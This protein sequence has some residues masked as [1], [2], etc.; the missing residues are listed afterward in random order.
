MDIMSMLDVTKAIDRDVNAALNCLPWVTREV[1]PVERKALV[2]AA[3]AALTKPAS[4]KQE[5]T[6]AYLCVGE[7]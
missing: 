2:N 7:G 3:L 1:T 6:S 5:L 4:L